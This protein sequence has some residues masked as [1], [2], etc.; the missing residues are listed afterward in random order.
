VRSGKGTKDEWKK[1]MEVWAIGHHSLRGRIDL[2]TVNTPSFCL[3]IGSREEKLFVKR[4]KFYRKKA[5]YEV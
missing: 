5:L 2:V 1:E 4:I 3:W